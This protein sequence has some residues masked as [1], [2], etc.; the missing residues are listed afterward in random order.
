[1]SR[2][3]DAPPLQLLIGP[4]GHGVVEYA[5]DIASALHDTDDRT[6]AIVVSGI[7]DALAAARTAPRTHLH[8]TDRLLGES[9]E[10]AADNLERLARVTRLT[11]T[12]HDVPQTSDGSGLARRVD[13]YTRMFAAAEAV[14]VNSRHEQQLAHEFLPAVA[15]PHAIPLGARR[16]TVPARERSP[17]DGGRL[18]VLLAGYIYPGKGHAT[19]IGAAADAAGMLRANGREVGNVVVRAIGGAAAG[20]EPDLR[21]IHADADRRGVRFDV[22]GFLDDAAFQANLLAGGIPLAAHEHV[23]ASRS[24]LDWVESGRRPLV[25]GSRYA[26][27][28]AALRPGTMTIYQPDELAGRLADAWRHPE[29]TWLEAGTSL[30]PTVGDAAEQ[31][32]TW[33]RTL[34]QR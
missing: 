4:R 20:H 14:T 30:H 11:I 10:R 29:Q 18:N 26:E 3:I 13:A 16:D 19:A 31:Y 32:R 25:V 33:W 9:P 5:A 1:M 24:M 15:A 17:S 22:T 12:A 8:V 7:D 21:R 6:T 34:A 2:V 28:M 23:S 27:E